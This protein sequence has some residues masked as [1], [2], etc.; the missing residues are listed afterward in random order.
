M[1][2]RKFAQMVQNR[3]REKL[4]MIHN[5]QLEEL[6]KEMNGVIFFFLRMNA[7]SDS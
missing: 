5:E 4:K 1:E 7:A 6:Q 3:E 2:E